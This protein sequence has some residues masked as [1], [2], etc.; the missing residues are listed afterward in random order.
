MERNFSITGLDHVE[1]DKLSGVG[2]IGIAEVGKRVL[3][4]GDDIGNSMIEKLRLELG[5][6]VAIIS[7][8]EAKELNLLENIPNTPLPKLKELTIPLEIKMLEHGE[9]KSGKE[10]RRDRRKKQ[11]MNKKCK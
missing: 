9:Y 4:L 6:R 8:N 3:I 7:T 1:S 2:V 11:K 10:N 5:D